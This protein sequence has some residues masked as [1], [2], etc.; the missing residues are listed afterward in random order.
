MESGS[1]LKAG[2]FTDLVGSTDLKQRRSQGRDESPD[3]A[4]DDHG[5]YRG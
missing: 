3:L 2:L 5:D 4:G 1:V